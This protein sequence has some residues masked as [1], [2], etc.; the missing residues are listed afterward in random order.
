MPK[1]I[2]KDDKYSTTDHLGNVYASVSEMCRCYDIPGSTY[3]NRL[4]YGWTVEQALTTPRDGLN[5][6]HNH[7]KIWRDHLGHEYNSVREMANAWGITEKMFWSRKRICKWPLEKILT[8]PFC[9]Q[10]STSKSCKDHKGREFPSVSAMCRH[11]GVKLSR[12]KERMKLGWDIKS[13]LLTPAKKINSMKAQPCV[14]HK[15]IEYPSKNAMCRAYGINRYT[16]AARLE[17]GWTLE[18]ALTGGYKINAKESVDYMGRKFPTLKDMANFYCVPAY[19]MQ[20]LKPDTDICEALKAFA[21]K[22]LVKRSFGN[23]DIRKCVKFPY[24]LVSIDG[25][26]SIMHLESILAAYHDSDI[27]EPLPKTKIEPVIKIIKSLGFP[28][29]LAEIDDK[30][31]VMSYWTIIDLNARSNFG[32]AEKGNGNRYEEL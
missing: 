26:E 29:Y 24:F 13:A 22:Y 25:A 31:S 9:E 7:K 10:P 14:D 6:K 12:F 32:L 2:P 28:Y 4:R 5:R 16:L 30:E 1:G 8:T 27:F 20:G 23:I 17:L 11:Y 15:G 21:A 3:N 18:Q 19:A